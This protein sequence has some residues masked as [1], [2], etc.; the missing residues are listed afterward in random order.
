MSKNVLDLRCLELLSAKP[1]G[2]LY[3]DEKYLINF[4]P[5]TNRDC[6]ADL[7]ILSPV[8]TLSLATQ[9]RELEAIA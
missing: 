1:R 4:G 7:V 2:L 5:L 3:T 6:S 9:R 8:G